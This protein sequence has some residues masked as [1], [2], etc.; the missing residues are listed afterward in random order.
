[1]R[2]RPSHGSVWSAPQRHQPRRRSAKPQSTSPQRRVV[3]RSHSGFA[4]PCVDATSVLLRCW[5]GPATNS[6]R[7]RERPPPGRCHSTARTGTPL[8][9]LTVGE[10]VTPPERTLYSLSGRPPLLR[11]NPP[12]NV[13]RRG[14]ASTQRALPTE[15]GTHIAVIG[16]HG[17]LKTTVLRTYLP[18]SHPAA[19]PRTPSLKQ[20]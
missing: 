14:D 12:R 10:G 4:G 7:A 17:A 6:G 16:E 13:T 5:G 19:A 8:A 9:A 11:R 18:R 1:M 15:L 20:S 2:W 3:G